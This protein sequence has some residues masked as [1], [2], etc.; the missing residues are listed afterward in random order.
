M[1]DEPLTTF[2]DAE[3]ARMDLRYY[4]A[5]IHRAAFILPQFA[6]KALLM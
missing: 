3:V 4:N 1:F 6:K 5:E 2:T